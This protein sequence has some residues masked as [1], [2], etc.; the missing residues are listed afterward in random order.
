ML[1]SRTLTKP[2]SASW[3]RT[4]SPEEDFSQKGN[5]SAKIKD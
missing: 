5:V 3:I 4:L 1:W 2:H